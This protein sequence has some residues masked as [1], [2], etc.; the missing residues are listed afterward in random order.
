MIEANDPNWDR[1]QATARAAKTDP[2]AWLAM[3]DIYGDVGKAPAFAGAF[4]HA[5]NTVWAWAPA[6]R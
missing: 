2:L 1:M 4:C 6:K 5:L 3:E